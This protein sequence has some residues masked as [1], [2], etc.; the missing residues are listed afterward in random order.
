MSFPITATFIDEITYDIPSSNWSFEQW[1]KDL[2]YM[3][4]VGIDTLVFIRAGYTDRS[5]FPSDY[6]GTH[7]EDDL[8]GFVLT[9]AEKRNMKVLVGTYLSNLCWNN[10]DAKTELEFNRHFINEIW[11]RYGDSPAFG[12]WYIPQE[13]CEDC[14]NIT[15]VMGG[16]SYM[17]K[18]KAENL[19]VFISPFFGAEAP[20]NFS[21]ERHVEEWNSIFERCGKNIDICAFQDGTVSMSKMRDFY[22]ATKNLCE[23][24]NIS[25]W[26]NAETF[27][28]DV[29]QMY[30][31]IP[32]PVLRRKLE[33]HKEYAE[34]IITFEF[35]HFLSPQSIYPSAKNLYNLYTE[36][37]KNK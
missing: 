25:H 12:G 13:T 30:F 36:Y 18:E 22:L 15:E 14:L 10:G 21:V 6:L 24:H 37:Y 28:R 19:P 33:M 7:Y 8:L 26:V 3:Q 11:T 17:C 1:S 23:A 35:S 5:I 20:R 9:E 4:T 2:D 31:P 34:K 16:I 29:R 32:F 27:E